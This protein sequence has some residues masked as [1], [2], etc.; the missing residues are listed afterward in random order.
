MVT[1]PSSALACG[2][3][4]RPWSRPTVRCGRMTS[5][6]I[7]APAAQSSD[8]AVKEIRANIP[9]TASGD[10]LVKGLVDMVATFFIEEQ[11]GE[12]LAQIQGMQGKKK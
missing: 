5:F 6:I 12:L 2:E 8:F 3:G 11:K 7:K 1:D 4:L 10:G 9:V